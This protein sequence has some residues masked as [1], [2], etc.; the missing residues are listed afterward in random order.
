MAGGGVVVV[1]CLSCGRGVVSS[2]GGSAGGEGGEGGL[3]GVGDCGSL[4]G[5]GSGVIG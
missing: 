5:D 1:V 2:V 3:I 4:S